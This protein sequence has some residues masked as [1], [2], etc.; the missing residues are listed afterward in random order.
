[1]AL[2]SNRF[3]KYIVQPDDQGGGTTAPAPAKKPNRFAKYAQPAPVAAQ[4]AQQPATEAPR[5]TFTG[6]AGVNPMVEMGQRAQ[7]VARDAGADMTPRDASIRTQPQQTQPTDPLAPVGSSP[8]ADLPKPQF[9]LPQGYSVIRSQQGGAAYGQPVLRAP[10]GSEWTQDRW[11]EV[12]KA[13]RDQEMQGKL[14]AQQHEQYRA[15]RGILTPISDAVIGGMQT[16]DSA[17][18]DAGKFVGQNIDRMGYKFTGKTGIADDVGNALAAVGGSLASPLDT[19]APG[20]SDIGKQLGQFGG[21]VLRNPAE[22][23]TQA[24]DMLEPT[25]IA[26]SGVSGLQEAMGYALK[27]DF[28]RAKQIAGPAGIETLIGAVG[29]LPG[30]GPIVDGLRAARGAPARALEADI[31]R[32]GRSFDPAPE[33][34]PAPTGAPASAAQAAPPPGSASSCSRRSTGRNRRGAGW[35]SSRSSHASDW[36]CA[37]RWSRSARTSKCGVV[38][39]R[40]RSLVQQPASEVARVDPSRVRIVR[41]HEPGRAGRDYR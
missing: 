32:A 4:P 9:E 10:D 37:L 7:Q 18:N 8:Q 33:P 30:S 34:A 6:S 14:A 19:V 22:A 26:A 24:T 16:A 23:A 38:A 17:I 29:M 31:A 5:G 36:R 2:A 13:A 27:G 35:S 40:G 12:I 28:E 25:H 20:V 15:D 1:M 21:T 3:A 11:N 41:C 39:W